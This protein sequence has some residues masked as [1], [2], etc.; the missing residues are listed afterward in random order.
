MNEQNLNLPYHGKDNTLS[1]LTDY[2][3]GNLTAAEQW[4]FEEVMHH[5]VAIS[6]AL[7][8]LQQVNNP[9][10]LHSIERALNK[11]ISKKITQKHKS[12]HKPLKF[13]MWIIL[14]ASIV[15]FT[16]LA[17]YVIIAMMN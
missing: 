9:N 14:L 16:V 5:D 6:D 10:E 1:M 17:G 15:L 3:R 11:S 4:E 12:L 13:P 7:E 8:G 2:V